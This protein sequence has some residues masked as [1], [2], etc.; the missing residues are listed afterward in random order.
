MR[1][2]AEKVSDSI[3]DDVIER[4]ELN[5][6]SS[7]SLRRE[8][9][10]KLL[11]YLKREVIER[12]VAA[13]KKNVSLLELTIDASLVGPYGM[14]LICD[15]I[16]KNTTVRNF[17]V[18][19]SG[20]SHF[21]D[22]RNLQESESGAM[23]CFGEMMKE[24]TSL[25]RL[26]VSSDLGPHSDT[27][28]K[29]LGLAFLENGG[30]CKLSSL[31]LASYSSRDSSALEVLLEG[32][33]TLRHLRE[34]DLSGPHLTSKSAAKIVQILSNSGSSNGPQLIHLGLK[35]MDLGGPQLA[36]ICDAVKINTALLRL[37]MSNDN[38]M[39]KEDALYI[40]QMI[41]DNSC[42]SHLWVPKTISSLSKGNKV[43]NENYNLVDA[44]EVNGTLLSLEGSVNC[45]HGFE[46]RLERNRQVARHVSLC[47]VAV[48]TGQKKNL[49]SAI[50][51]DMTLMLMHALWATRGDT[52]SWSRFVIAD[53]NTVRQTE[54]KRRQSKLLALFKKR[55]P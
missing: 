2:G 37:D 27:I 52:A 8:D 22:I 24:N 44:L 47:I 26:E 31:L 29:T 40:A 50:P 1:A 36:V 10:R 20:L 46:P 39:W 34:L 18:F 15:V 6:I 51:K 19:Q 21:T 41:R 7:V 55:Q 13:L 23:A 35:Y 33:S 45:R 12:F 49:L 16:K 11:G 4:I 42:L 5:M 48:M 25:T 43:G 54:P 53:A 32:V 28:F 14:E 17:F 30:K 3:M 38:I 9:H